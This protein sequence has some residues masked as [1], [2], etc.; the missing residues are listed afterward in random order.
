M[1]LSKPDAG[2]LSITSLCTSPDHSRVAA[3]E[4]HELSQRITFWDRNMAVAQPPISADVK[5]QLWDIAW[6][7]DCQYLAGLTKRRP[8]DPISPRSDKPSWQSIIYYWRPDGTVMCSVECSHSIS[9]ILV[10]PSNSAYIVSVGEHGQV[11]Y[12]RRTK[13]VLSAVPVSGLHLNSAGDFAEAGTRCTAVTGLHCGLTIVAVAGAASGPALLVIDRLKVVKRYS[14]LDGPINALRAVAD[15]SF[16]AA[17]QEHQRLDLY[18]NELEHEEVA[19]KQRGVAFRASPVAEVQQVRTLTATEGGR[20]VCMYTAGVGCLSLCMD[21]GAVL[22]HGKADTWEECM[23]GFHTGA[24]IS[25][26]VATRRTLL[27]SASDDN[28]VRV[29]DYHRQSCRAVHQPAQPVAAVALHPWGTDLIIAHREFAFTYV[30]AGSELVRGHRLPES[31]AGFSRLRYSPSGGY[32]AAVHADRVYVYATLT[33]TLEATLTGHADEVSDIAWSRDGFRLATCS[34]TSVYLWSMD[35]MQRYE[36]DTT[37]TWAN[38]A[39]LPDPAFH[40]VLVA[41]AFWGLRCFATAR[42]GTGVAEAAAHEGAVEIAT[43]AA[44]AAGAAPPPPRGARASAAGSRHGTSAGALQERSSRARGADVE[45]MQLVSKGLGGVR[46]PVSCMEFSP[47]HQCVVAKMT[48]PGE[49]SSAGASMVSSML[50]VPFPPCNDVAMEA[51]PHR[52]A[53]AAV[54][55]D[56]S[57]D[58]VFSCDTAGIVLMHALV[59][60]SP[61]L[62]PE[63]QVALE[64]GQPFTE[65]YTSI[66]ARAFALLA[67]ADPVKDN[68]ALACMLLP[69]DTITSMHDEIRYLREGANVHQTE[70]EWQRMKMQHQQ[71]QDVAALEQKHHS[72]QQDLKLAMDHLTA[73]NREEVAEVLKRAAEQKAK[74]EERLEE[75]QDWI[76]KRL[77]REMDRTGLAEAEVATMKVKFATHLRRLQE[78]TDSMEAAHAASKDGMQRQMQKL[79]SDA[80]AVLEQWRARLELELLLEAS[81]NAEDVERAQ[82]DGEAAVAE[83]DRRFMKLFADYQLQKTHLARALTDTRAADRMR[84]DAERE[85]DR[86][87]GHISKLEEQAELQ[88][89]RDKERSAREEAEAALKVDNEERM[90]RLT[91]FQAL[92]SDRMQTQQASL[93]PLMVNLKQSHAELTEAEN[94]QGRNLRRFEKLL[95]RHRVLEEA[96]ATAQR[97]AHERR[98]EAALLRQH[99]AGVLGAVW[100]AIHEE[101]IERWP[102][103]MGHLY[104]EHFQGRQAQ[105]WTAGMPSDGTPTSPR[106]LSPELPVAVPAAA[107]GV[108][109]PGVPPGSPEQRHASNLARA[110]AIAEDKD[111]QAALVREL[112]G[113]LLAAEQLIAQ[114]AQSVRIAQRGRDTIKADMVATNSKLLKVLNDVQRDNHTLRS[115]VSHLEAFG[116]PSAAR[117]SAAP[118]GARTASARPPRPSAVSFAKLLGAPAR[119]STSPAQHAADS[120]EALGATVPGADAQQLSEMSP[121]GTGGR[122][123]RVTAGSVRFALQH[124]AEVRATQESSGSFEAAAAA[125]LMLTPAHAGS[126]KGLGGEAEDRLES[127]EAGA[128]QQR[129]CSMGGFGSVEASGVLGMLDRP[130]SSTAAAAVAAIA[131]Y[132]GAQRSGGSAPPAD[133]GA[134]GM[135]RGRTRR[136]AEHG[137]VRSPWLRETAETVGAKPCVPRVIGSGFRVQS[138]PSAAVRSQR[139]AAGGVADGTAQRWL[140]RPGAA[141]GA[142]AHKLSHNDGGRMGFRGCVSMDDVACDEGTGVA[143]HMGHIQQQLKAASWRDRQARRW[144]VLEGAA[145]VAAPREHIAA[146][147]RQARPGRLPAGRVSALLGSHKPDLA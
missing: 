20:H 145:L 126:N 30:V 117:A 23:P 94:L 4:R 61:P 69:E 59:S 54:A 87:R 78:S 88:A 40:S 116:D 26:S 123:C 5:G 102:G 140:E 122:P 147:S 35:T 25:L 114:Q 79:Q 15:R 29:W 18:L 141:H 50:L 70:L 96:A 41:D 137:A 71:E 129:Q 27:A 109:S 108:S 133:G 73:R 34:Q 106:A 142:E 134:M 144:N 89:R 121:D 58:I 110:A 64:A 32:L 39:V 80:G 7:A 75:Q 111:A 44:A 6:S 131:A 118:A 128:R 57:G 42:G 104:N 36:E 90:R 105:K 21:K 107:A 8:T 83:R 85:A 92:A 86:L 24:V 101:P 63:S 93:G 81:L 72:Q 115:R 95:W 99:T 146:A 67:A 74:F 10:D 43:P 3:I 31:A 112:S 130:G 82:G 127:T 143:M 38:G 91:T 11:M 68:R 97:E 60:R 47:R 120:P 98:T 113:N 125:T 28:T 77:A 135:A 37:R 53:V 139:A 100:R 16:V 9:Q 13:A 49:A 66:R 103:I 2:V 55:M 138:A 65:P 17:V 132:E 48:H 62:T 84:Q 22:E 124:G 33:Y 12:W 56:A 76:E 51:E 14:G 119:P 46:R 19:T 45:S 1:R 136:L 52:A